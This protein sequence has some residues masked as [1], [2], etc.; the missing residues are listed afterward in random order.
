M[1][2]FGATLEY[3]GYVSGQQKAELLGRARALLYP[4]QYPEAFGLVLVEAMLCGT[5]VVAMGIG[6]AP[7]IVEQGVTGFCAADRAEFVRGVPKAF[8]LP[9]AAIRAAA[10]QRFS[11]SRMTQ[12][13]LEVYQR[14]TGKHEFA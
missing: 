8:A 10:E 3:A 5:P 11:A 7:E 2:A 14:L 6:A 1:D 9:R 4:I 13:Y 12:G